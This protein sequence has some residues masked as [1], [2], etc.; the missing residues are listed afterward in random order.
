MDL[1][2]DAYHIIGI[3]KQGMV[4]IQLRHALAR[5]SLI[6]VH[7]I[8]A[9]INICH[10]LSTDGDKRSHMDNNHPLLNL[11]YRSDKH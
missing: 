10:N 3:Q 9:D 8:V 6:T 11:S 7:K 1:G 2:G 5:K 4:I